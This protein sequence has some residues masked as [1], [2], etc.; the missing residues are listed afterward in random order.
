MVSWAELLRFAEPPALSP[1]PR[2]GF[3][4]VGDRPNKAEN[5]AELLRFVEPRGPKPPPAEARN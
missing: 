4:G 2:S 3:G 5:R 1:K